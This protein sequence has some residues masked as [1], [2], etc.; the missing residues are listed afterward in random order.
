MGACSIV[1]GADFSRAKLE[2][3]VWAASDT[4]HACFRNA[5]MRKVNFFAINCEGAIF[6]GAD[7]SEANLYSPE[8]WLQNQ[9]PLDFTGANLTGAEITLS[10]PLR[11]KLTDAKIKGLRICLPESKSASVKEMNEN[12]LNI[13][14]EGLDH[15]QRSQLKIIR[16][17][18]T[19]TA[20]SPPGSTNCFI[21]T[22]CYESF[23]TPEVCELRR[24]RDHVLLKTT[25]GRRF[26]QIYYRI[27]PPIARF[28]QKNPFL[29][30]A[31]KCA[32]LDPIVRI[33]CRKNAD[34]CT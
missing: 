33:V 10:T 13:F 30:T 6:T 26:I 5:N 8:G 14:L 4:K 24:F 34:A 28:I 29:K 11:F 2:G 32:I 20:G 27:S 3:S 25:N 1:D 17:S 16:K 31:I 7:L 12:N 21:A 19:K 18:E 23:S 22:A 9:E 15:E